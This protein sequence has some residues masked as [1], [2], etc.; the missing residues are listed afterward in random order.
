MKDKIESVV[1]LD[2]LLSRPSDELVELFSKLEGDILFLGINGKIGRS[3]AQMAKRA[4]DLTELKRRI[5]GLGRF[6]N[7]SDR[8]SLEALGIE[9][10]KGDIAIL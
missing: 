10:I 2:E 4:S 9:T 3:M 7:D 1:E 8:T 6:D 5:I